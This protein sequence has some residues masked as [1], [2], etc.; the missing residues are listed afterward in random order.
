MIENGSLGKKIGSII[1][2]IIIILGM[3]VLIQVP[4]VFLV[5]FDKV[6]KKNNNA[7]SILLFICWLLILTG[8]VWFIWGYYKKK[9]GDINTKITGRDVWRA[10]KFFLLGRLVAL[11]GTGLMEQFY[12]D[13][14]SANDESIKSLF[15]SDASVYFVLLMTISIAISG[16]ILEELV[17]RGI[18]TALLFKKTPKWVPLILTSLAFSSVHKFT[19][20]ISFGMYAMLG[21]VMYWS[22]S[23]RGRIV[24]S[25]LVHFFNNIIGAV[26]LLLAYF[27]GQSFF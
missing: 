7:V 9:S 24:D 20:P 6:F 26:A 1:L 17:F 13:G 16:P 2:G 4:Q 8:I 21:V 18:P 25:M 14:T 11:I 12:G 10:F 23:Y 15:S 3:F 5:L 22:Y 19:N 27:T